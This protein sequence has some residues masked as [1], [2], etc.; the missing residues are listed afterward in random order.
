MNLY[1]REPEYILETPLE[2]TIHSSAQSKDTISK[3]L[4]LIVVKSTRLSLQQ[5]MLATTLREILDLE[6]ELEQL[7]EEHL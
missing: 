2:K 7:V 4:D 6:Q 3:L 5:S 1:P